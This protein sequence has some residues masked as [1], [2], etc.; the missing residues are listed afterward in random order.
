[1][2]RI[3]FPLSP[4]QEYD[5][6]DEEQVN[7]ERSCKGKQVV[8]IAGVG[9]QDSE[10][11]C[12]RSV[13]EKTSDSGLEF[14]NWHSRISLQQQKGLLLVDNCL[15]KIQCGMNVP[16]GEEDDSEKS[17]H[18]NEYRERPCRPLCSDKPGNDRRNEKYHYEIAENEKH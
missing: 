13:Y 17:I 15:R 5:K 7:L 1:D 3:P 4:D 10:R 6:E 9:S 2:A 12:L 8:H 16:G 14:G 11:N 18:S